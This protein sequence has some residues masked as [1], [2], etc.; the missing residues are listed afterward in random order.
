MIQ[1]K[2]HKKPYVTFFVGVLTALLLLIFYEN[3]FAHSPT[4]ETFYKSMKNT[5][6]KKAVTGLPADI[7]EFL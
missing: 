6:Q 4:V 7:H 1:L 5:I 3:V 2:L